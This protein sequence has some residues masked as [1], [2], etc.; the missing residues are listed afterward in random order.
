M[1]RT[2][3]R[4]SIASLACL[5][6]AL[7][8]PAA[9]QQR[10]LIAPGN[11]AV[12]AIIIGI[13]AYQNVRPLKGA[14][15]DARDLEGALRRV[16]VKDVTAL[17]DAAANR[18]EVFNAIAQ[19]NKRIKP[20]DLVVLSLAGH[21]AQEPEK[22]KGSQPDGMD[23]VFLL[24]GFAVTPNGSRQRILGR[25]FNSIIKDF[26]A[27]GAHVI[28]VADTCYGGGLTREVD[29]RD[30]E[31]SYR[32]TPR[33]VLT[34]DDLKPVGTVKDAYLTKLDFRQTAF[35][36]AVDRRTMA[37]E[38]R[39]PGIEGYRG[40]LSYAV[41]RAF[42]G[43]A[44]VNKDGKISLQELFGYVRSLV[45]QLS[46]ERQV[47]VMEAA[48]DLQINTAL[49]F[50]FA[51]SAAPQLPH[52]IVTAAQDA[53]PQP[54][55]IPASVV[56]IA[57]LDPLLGSISGL[58]QRDAPFQIIASTRSADLVW[59][60]HSGDVLAHGDVIA[61]NLQKSDLP[62][63][64][65]RWAAVSGIK[66]LASLG[67][68]SIK[69][70]PDDKLHHKDSK[71]VVDISGVADRALILFNIAGD[72]TVQALYPKRG[73]LPILPTANYQLPV[74][75]RAPFGADQ[76]VAVTAKD[77]MPALQRAIEE[78][79]D[80]RAPVSAVESIKRYAPADARIG[81]VGIYTAP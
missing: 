63:V 39:I 51:G 61:H 50:A 53:P 66:H 81:T 62:S 11:G 36:A 19:V 30:A 18:T 2:R 44:D 73:D 71:V 15:A 77:K 48:P 41:A 21:G 3:M 72:G 6:L 20:G 16:G 47:P 38:V 70:E 28:F 33:Y 8:V 14:A 34:T 5:A 46:D 7:L 23:D 29:P 45:Y 78:L 26:E 31:M 4:R 10:M 65:D 22:I 64:V 74:V 27:L 32:Q 24:A 17:I 55:T 49:A 43:R 13:D 25:E 68:Q 1:K 60:P 57:S 54:P 75:V 59:D 79:N 56:R 80:R 69:V 42:E 9:A 35:L 37:P 12:H 52:L 67:P 58:E 76:I 40:A